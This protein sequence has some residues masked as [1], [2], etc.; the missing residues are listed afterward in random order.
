VNQDAHRRLAGRKGALRS[1]ANTVDRSSRTAPARANGPA[2]LKWH[3]ER[4]PATFDGATDAQRLAAAEAARRAYF[5]DLA[6][7]SVRARQ[8]DR[9]TREKRQRRD[10]Q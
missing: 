5:A 2:E 7:R 1:W 6:M 9:E 3:I 4:L 8:A 10:Q